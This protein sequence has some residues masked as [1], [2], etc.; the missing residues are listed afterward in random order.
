METGLSYLKSGM[1]YPTDS[2]HMRNV[3][4]GNSLKIS[5]DID[6]REMMT[7][8]RTTFYEQR[9]L[10]LRHV[11]RPHPGIQNGGKFYRHDESL[12]VRRRGE[13]K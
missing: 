13:G 4:H 2:L 9:K 6:R 11:Y 5:R 10:V 1:M 12:N 7:I 3:W 8:I